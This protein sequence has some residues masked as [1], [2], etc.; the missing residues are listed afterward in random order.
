MLYIGI[1]AIGLGILSTIAGLILLAISSFSQEIAVRQKCKKIATRVLP[2]AVI[3][4]FI[5]TGVV[6]YLVGF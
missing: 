3:L 1:L 2:V 6:E 5:G 4:L